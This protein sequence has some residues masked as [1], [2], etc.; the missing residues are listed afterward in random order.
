MQNLKSVN[1]SKSM[2]ISIY[3]IMFFIVLLMPAISSSHIVVGSIVNFSLIIATY[4]F[5]VRPSLVMCFLPSLVALAFGLIFYPI[6]I[7]FI[8]ISNCLLVLFFNYMIKKKRASFSIFIASLVKAFFLCVSF[9]F[10]EFSYAI[11]FSLMQVTSLILG[12][13]LTYSFLKI[14]DIK[15]AAK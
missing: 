7:P 11:L 12:G 2:Y 4:Y 1:L 8:M 15:K 6:L 3:F 14:L 10:L 9:A 5:G 13:T